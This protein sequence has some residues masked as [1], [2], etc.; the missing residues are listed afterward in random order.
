V[1]VNAA[2][3]APFLRSAKCFKVEI[4]GITIGAFAS[5]SGLQVEF[6]VLEYAEGG[7]NGFVH[8]LRGATRYANLVLAHGVT[9]ET[10]LL[11]WIF[12]FQ[13][14][15]QR[16]TVTVTLMDE[17]SDT[18]RSWAFSQGFPLRW[19]GPTLAEETGTVA[20]ETLEIGHNGLVRP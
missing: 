14:L 1:A 12:N 10:G 19:T 3:A 2:G 17:V 4:P 16:P 15:G 18:V 9:N 20:T 7:E 11:D 8:K 5:C 13:E 6:D